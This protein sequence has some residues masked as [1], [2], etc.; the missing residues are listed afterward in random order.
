MVSILKECEW[1]AIHIRAL[2]VFG[3]CDWMHPMQLWLCHL[4]G[5]TTTTILDSKHFERLSGVLKLSSVQC[6]IFCCWIMWILCSF[7]FVAWLDAVLLRNVNSDPDHLVINNKM[8][9]G[10]IFLKTAPIPQD[11]KHCE[12]MWGGYNSH[13]CNV[14]FGLWDWMHP[15]QLWPCHLVGCTTTLKLDSKHFERV[16][17]VL[18][19][20]SVQCW[21]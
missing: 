1:L 7:G 5:W 11:C 16:S 9:R 12:R 15:I 8:H 19:L 17:G 14:G 4:V 21:C 18:Q 2:L 20:S 13:Q 3:L 10:I 6:W